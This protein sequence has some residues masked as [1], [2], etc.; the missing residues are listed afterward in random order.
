MGK[1]IYQLVPIKQSAPNSNEVRTIWHE[2]QPLLND[3]V[4]A[5]CQYLY[6]HEL[7]VV[8]EDGSTNL[9]YTEKTDWLENTK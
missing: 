8:H 7:L 3:K 9:Y 4:V 5:F 6:E 1:E 2:S